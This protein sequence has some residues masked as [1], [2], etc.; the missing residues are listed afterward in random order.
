MITKQR[1]SISEADEKLLGSI[2]GCAGLTEQ[3]VVTLMVCAGLT[4]GD[5]LDH[6]EAI[7]S[8]RVH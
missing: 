5:I 7:T 2:S 3:E 6:L 8:N 1:L 4:L